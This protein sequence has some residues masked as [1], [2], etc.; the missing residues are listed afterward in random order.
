MIQEN[1]VRQHVYSGQ[2][3][4]R[5]MPN[6][7]GTVRDIWLIKT[8]RLRLLF[9]CQEREREERHRESLFSENCPDC[10]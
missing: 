8:I 1:V 5:E 6:T 2:A 7:L 10:S 4:G 3:R 9:V